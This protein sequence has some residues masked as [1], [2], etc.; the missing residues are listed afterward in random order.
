[1]KTDFLFAGF[2]LNTVVQEK[3][4]DKQPLYWMMLLK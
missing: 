1:M 2:N 4:P 3:T